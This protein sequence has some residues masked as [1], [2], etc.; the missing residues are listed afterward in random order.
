MQFFSQC[1][2]GD[3]ARARARRRDG[4]RPPPGQASGGLGPHLRLSR[5]A[6]AERGHHRRRASRRGFGQLRPRRHPLDRRMDR[7][8]LGVPGP[9]S[10]APSRR[11]AARGRSGRPLPFGLRAQRTASGR[12]LGLRDHADAPRRTCRHDGPARSAAS[13]CHADH[14]VRA[15]RRCGGVRGLYADR[16][17][18][19]TALARIR[20][21]RYESARARHSH[22]GRGAQDVPGAPPQRPGGTAGFRERSASGRPLALISDHRGAC[23]AVDPETGASV[24]ESCYRRAPVASLGV[25]PKIGRRREMAGGISTQARI[26]RCIPSPSHVAPCACTGYITGNCLEELS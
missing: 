21:F 11:P 12:G 19:E 20:P 4:L 25:L 2:A 5:G 6:V 14:L 22:R 7:P 23:R 1:Y 24:T 9:R 26:A 13:A 16:P 15:R 10:P 17:C 8:P 3:I 18:G